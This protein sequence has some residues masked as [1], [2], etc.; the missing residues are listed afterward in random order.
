MKQQQITANAPL[1]T[2]SSARGITAA[3]QLYTVFHIAFK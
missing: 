2:S 1:S 3:Y